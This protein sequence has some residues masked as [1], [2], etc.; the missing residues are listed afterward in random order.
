[1]TFT[2]AL[3]SGDRLRALADTTIACTAGTA[4]SPI[5]TGNYTVSIATTSTDHTFSADSA[6]GAYY[7]ID[8]GGVTIASDVV[9]SQEVD[10]E[11]NEK[12]T[13][14]VKFA[15]KATTLPRI[16]G[17]NFPEVEIPCTLDEAGT[18]ATCSPTTEHLKEGDNKI[19]MRTGCATTGTD[20][21]I[22]VNMKGA[23][24]MIALGKVLLIALAAFLL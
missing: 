12:K 7:R 19:L 5:A 20:T 8:A 13:F 23:S 14:A 1:M 4:P 3:T 11:D 9:K 2:C 10:L 21:T 15:A 16:Y 6:T 17:E 18:T 22:V 24:S